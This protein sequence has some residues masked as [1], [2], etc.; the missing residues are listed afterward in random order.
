MLHDCS[1]PE[2][3]E[4]FEHAVQE[5]ITYLFGEVNYGCAS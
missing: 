3:L 2:D 4:M 5:S 1:F